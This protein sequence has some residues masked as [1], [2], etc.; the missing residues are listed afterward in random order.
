MDLVALSIFLLA[1]V[2]CSVFVFIISVYGTKE[3]TFEE[4]LKASHE[5]SSKKAKSEAKKK[6]K[7]KAEI[8]EPVS[9]VFLKSW[10]R[11]IK[12]GAGFKSFRSRLKPRLPKNPDRRSKRS[13]QP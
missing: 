11:F 2:V 12:Y 10:F 1:V 3:V 13:K 4:N 7:K 8:S 9:P 5:S 6:N